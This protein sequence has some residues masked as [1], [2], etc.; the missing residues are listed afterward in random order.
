MAKILLVE[1]D[2]KLAAAI[3]RALESDLH[4][5]E[6]VNSGLDGLDRLM[7][8]TFDVAILDWVLPEIP[9]VA[10][11]TQ[12]RAGGG[13]TPILMLTGKSAIGDISKGLDAGAD[14]Y[15]VKPFN[16]V[17]LNARVRALLRRLPRFNTSTFNCGDL[18]LCIKTHRVSRG[19]EDIHLVPKEFAL[20]EFFM[21][22]PNQVFST[23][24][25]LERVWPADAEVSPSLVKTY[26]AKLRS[27]LDRDGDESIIRTVHGLGYIMSSKCQA[28]G[29]H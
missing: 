28:E 20:L 18:T 4:A 6:V 27:K 9:G 22:H 14:D 26:I 8:Y 11:C 29:G 5:V 19:G 25:L 21:R 15:L 12:F 23:D 17:E 16:P 7:N 1:D 24:S 13:T 10:I 3:S 2:L